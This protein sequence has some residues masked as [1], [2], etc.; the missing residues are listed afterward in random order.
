MG[1]S[2]S[3]LNLSTSNSRSFE[4][5]MDYIAT[6]YILTSNFKNLTKLNDKKYCD[7]M[8]VLTSDIIQKQFNDMEIT[9]LAQ[10]IKNGVEV[11]EIKKDNVIFLNKDNLDISTPLTKKRICSGIAKFYIKIAHLFS[12]IIMTIN[13]VY[14]YKDEYDNVITKNVMEKDE[15]PVNARDRKVFRKGICQNRINALTKGQDFE[16][17]PQ[18][19]IIKINPNICSF[20]SEPRKKEERDSREMDPREILFRESRENPLVGPREIG[21]RENPQLQKGGKLLNEEPGIPEL[22]DLYLDK[23]NYQTGTFTDMT[24]ETKQDYLNDLN[25]FYML[26]TGEKVMPSNINKFSDIKLRDYSKQKGCEM[27]KPVK[28]SLKEVLFQKYALHLQKMVKKTNDNQDYLLDIINGIFTYDIVDGVK[29]IRINPNLTEK[30]LDDLVK[31]TRKIIVDLY[32]SCENDFIEGVKIYEAIVENQIRATTESQLNELE[33]ASKSIKFYYKQ[34]QMQPQMQPHPQPQQQPQQ[35]QRQQ[36]QQQP[37]M[38]QQM[39]P[40][41]QPQ[42]QQQMQPQM[43]QIIQ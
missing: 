29:K 39:Q 3:K 32:L 23:Y 13:P 22:F 42:M 12:A 36:P 40:K 1:S 14:T 31:K 8:V 18:D 19:G 28:G 37:Q 17:I 11:N 26:F 34:P 2:N 9:Y 33:N 4:N 25:N 6:Y 10:R 16:N 27:G 15:I 7:R 35:Q 41:M 38:Q 5:V 30:L 24:N 43:Q 20:N 21:P